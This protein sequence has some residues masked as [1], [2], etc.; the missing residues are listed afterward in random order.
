MSN[1]AVINPVGN[2]LTTE[3]VDLIKTTICRGATDDELKMFV[4]VCGQT[5]LNPFTKQIHA[6]K[7]W[8]SKLNREVMAIQVAIDGFRLIAQRTGMYAGQQGPYWCGDDGVWHD[9]WLKDTP[10]AAAKVGVMRVGFTEPLTAV[11]RWTSYVQKGK[12]GNPTKFWQNMPDLM[13]AKCAEGLALRK[14]FPQELSSLYTPEELAQA[15][16]PEPKPVKVATVTGELKTKIPTWSDEQ[17]RE[18][19]TIRADIIRWGGDAGDKE[20]MQLKQRMKYDDPQDVIDA[21]A[22]LARRWEDVHM[23]AEEEAAAKGDR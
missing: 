14:A 23:Q 10:P 13:L 9:V 18:A 11:A 19:G 3:Q 5:G 15:D 4:Q 12:D 16:N 1:N 20:V 8:D 22:V 21:L 6:V 17:A 2:A 7:R